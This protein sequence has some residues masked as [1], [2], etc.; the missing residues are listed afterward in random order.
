VAYAGLR[1][2]LNALDHAGKLHRVERE[3]DKG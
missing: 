3:V 2:Y 1:E